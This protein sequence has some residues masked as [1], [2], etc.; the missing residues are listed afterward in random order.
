MVSLLEVSGSWPLPYPIGYW[1]SS[2]VF[3]YL[4]HPNLFICY[5]VIY[6][7]VSVLYSKCYILVGFLFRF[8]FSLNGGV[9]SGIRLSCMI[10]AEIVFHHSHTVCVWISFEP[11]PS[12]LICAWNGRREHRF[13]GFC[14]TKQV[15]LHSVLTYRFT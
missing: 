2:L 13:R 9:A 15:V 11:K 5:L 14:F 10:G 1:V 4:F 8:L 7:I 6:P 3:S 12:C